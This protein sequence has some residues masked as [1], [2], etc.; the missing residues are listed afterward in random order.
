MKRLPGFF[1]CLMLIVAGPSFAAAPG[2]IRASYGIYKAGIKIGQVD[3]VFSISKDNRYTIVS[4]TR[5]TGLLAIFRRGR[6]ILR[7]SGL[8]DAHGLKP[9]NFSDV[10]E[11]DE[12]RNRSAT[13]NWN[14][15]QLTL[16]GHNQRRVM[17]LPD[18]TQDRLSAMYQFL[19]LSLGNTDTLNFHMTNG[20]KLDIYNYTV[21]HDRRLTIPL[22]SFDALYIASVPE[23][24]S[25][26]TEIWLAGKHT[27][28]PYKIVITDPDGGQLSQVLTRIVT[29]P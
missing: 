19:F 13:F 18:D 20:D 17:P 10:R 6:I 24:G 9:L 22:G 23:K 15:M 7:S 27:D 28:F 25:N 21:A 8:V 4:T 26:R 2:S 5:A 14:K 3:E 12:D 16:I 1:A 11:G 29:N